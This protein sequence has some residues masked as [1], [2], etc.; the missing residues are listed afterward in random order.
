M[1]QVRV[2]QGILEGNQRRGVFRFRGVPY[3]APP[4]GNLRWAA[5]RPPAAWDGV[6][7]ATS[8]GNAAIQTADNGAI[9]GAQQSEDCLYLNVWTASLDPQARRPVMVWIHGG[10]FLNG[11]GSMPDY[12]GTSIAQRGVTYVSF[13]YRLGAFGFLDHPEA[14]GNAAVRDWVAALDWVSR[15][16]TAF[17]GDPGNVTIFGQ[18]AGASAARTLLATP[19]ARGLFHRAILQS[20][21]FELP[22]ALPH[23]ARERVV[24]ASTRLFE[25]LGGSDIEHLRQV[26]VDQVRQA[27]RLLSGTMPPPGEVHTP[28]NLVWF[29][30]EDGQV[31]GP[32]LSCWEADVPV[33]FGHTGDEARFFIRPGGPYGAPPGTVN[34]AE[35][36]TPATLARMAT[37]LGGQRA[38]DI[39][40]RLTGSP[41]E[42]LAEL[43]TSAIWTEPALASYLRFTD[44]GRTTYAYRF[45][46]V[47][48]GNRATGMLAF[49]C[50]ELPYAF[51]HLLPAE[52]Y[53]EVD[54]HVSGTL[55]H[56]WTEFARTGVPS[57]PDGTPWP[58][59]TRTAP[60]LTL[61]DDK[62]HSCPLDIGPTT[63]MINS[64]RAGR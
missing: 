29:P 39:L 6:R 38:D 30:T 47:S 44:L 25:Q 42:A 41:Y 13:N 54:A 43:F 34:P 18:S 9:L 15:N 22:A 24:E 4:V 14:G 60:R 46:R 49:H 45:V 12:H 61:I 23:S 19:T 58:A 7:D 62:A 32:D 11:A 57:S 26:P 31:V 21:G 5:P 33:L 50:S 63:E 1:T 35:L 10:G 20:A 27:S 55:A 51:G 40:G 52:D 16:I 2:E 53:D 28:A 59:A 3:A 17:G 64:L 48:P 8:F 36:Y 37:V 56:A